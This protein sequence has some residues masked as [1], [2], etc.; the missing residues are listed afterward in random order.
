[1]YDDYDNLTITQ[2]EA[3]HC[4]YAQPPEPLEQWIAQDFEDILL[5]MDFYQ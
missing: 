5:S 2:V 4:D 1:M 3:N